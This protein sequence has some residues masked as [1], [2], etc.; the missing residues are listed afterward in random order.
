MSQEVEEKARLLCDWLAEQMGNGANCDH[1]SGANRKDN[2]GFSIDVPVSLHT[3]VKVGCAARGVKMSD[4][5]RELL[6]REFPEE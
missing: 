3:R 2:Y 5:I 4:V 1:D 6:E